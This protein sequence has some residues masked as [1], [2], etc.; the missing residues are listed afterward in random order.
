MSTQNQQGSRPAEVSMAL[1]GYHLSSKWLGHKRYKSAAL[2]SIAI[3]GWFHRWLT[4]AGV[5]GRSFRLSGRVRGPAVVAEVAGVKQ[6]YI[7]A[8]SFCISPWYPL[9]VTNIAVENHNF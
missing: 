4:Q 2:R 7:G 1:A 3:A 6:S 5:D 9:V 8:I